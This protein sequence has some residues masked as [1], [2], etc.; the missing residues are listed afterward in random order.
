MGTGS[1]AKRILAKL[2]ADTRTQAAAIA[3][4]N[5]LIE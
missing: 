3:I 4:R 5:G 2:D 1:E